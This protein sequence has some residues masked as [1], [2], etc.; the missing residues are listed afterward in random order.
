MQPYSITEQRQAEEALRENEVRLSHA[1]ELL[2]GIVYWEHDEAAQEYIFNDAFYA[3]YGT[4]AD[5]E[6]GYR[7]ARDKYFEGS[8]IQRTRRR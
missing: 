7:M 8:C 6:G 5:R 2:A 1:T 4:T 3:L